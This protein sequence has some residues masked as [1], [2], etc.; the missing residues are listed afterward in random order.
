LPTAGLVNDAVTYAKMQNV[1]ATDRLLGRSTAG[2]GDPEEIVCTAAGRALIDD[3]DA[4]AQRTTLGLGTVAT[5]TYTEG[6]YTAGISFAGGTTGI[7]YTTQSGRYTLIGRMCFVE[8]NV[9]LSNKGSSTGAIRLTGLPFAAVAVI[10]PGAMVATNMTGMTTS[11][12]LSFE[13]PNTYAV[14]YQTTATGI[15][16][17]DNTNATNTSSFR[18][19]LAYF[20][21]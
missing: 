8:G 18:Y 6:T 11:P 19:A 20:V 21:S 10:A 13:S 5:Q 7:T 1:S 12:I 16:A 4:S 9:V 17:L 15:A 2:A 14:V 3:A